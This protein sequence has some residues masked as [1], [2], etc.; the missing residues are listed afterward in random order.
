VAL[1]VGGEIFGFLG[2]LLAVPAAAVAKIFV[3]HAVDYYRTTDLYR[4][5]PSRSVVQR[6]P[7]NHD[8]RGEANPVEHERELP[9]PS[10]N[11]RQEL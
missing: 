8:N 2:V 6:S 9:M 5:E 11:E 4:Q 1:F 3:A 7:A 10:E